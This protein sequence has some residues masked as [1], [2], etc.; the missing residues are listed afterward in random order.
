[1]SKL[2]LKHSSGRLIANKESGELMTCPFRQMIITERPNI[3]NMKGKD[4][5][6]TNQPCT[7]DCAKFVFV[8]DKE[9]VNKV[10]LTCG[11]GTAYEYE[12]EKND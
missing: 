5:V 9:G 4:I 1:M 6:Q 11:V 8:I 2:K 10:H 7:S 12:I 3:G